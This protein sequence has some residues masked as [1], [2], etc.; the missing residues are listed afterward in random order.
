MHSGLAYILEWRE[1]GDAWYQGMVSEFEMSW[2]GIADKYTHIPYIHPAALKCPH[3]SRPTLLVRRCLDT[4]AQ[5]SK[6]RGT[7]TPRATGVTIHTAT[8]AIS[9][10]LL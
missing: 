2:V 1:L 7:R 5:Q 8:G 9:K 4:I 3:P 6:R 10:P